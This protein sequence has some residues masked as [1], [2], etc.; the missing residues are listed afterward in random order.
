MPFLDCGSHSFVVVNDYVA[1]STERI[2]G[3]E[4]YYFCF[5]LIFLLKYTV[6]NILSCI[7]NT[8]MQFGWLQTRSYWITQ[9]IT[10]YIYNNKITF[11][12]LMQVD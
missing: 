9:I 7:S 5:F 11:C 1:V 12:N 8:K 6:Y 10:A 3:P 2:L 4:T